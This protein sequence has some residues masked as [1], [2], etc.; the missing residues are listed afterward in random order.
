MELTKKIHSLINSIKL[1][2]KNEILIE[3]N[4][5]LIGKIKK[6]YQ[7]LSYWVLLNLIHDKVN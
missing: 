7:K 4:L 5:N 2:K 3:E 1:Q 6:I